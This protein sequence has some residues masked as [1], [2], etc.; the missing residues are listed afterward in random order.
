M[1][2]WSKKKNKFS[3]IWSV[4]PFGFGLHYSTYLYFPHSKQQSY[5]TKRQTVYHKCKHTFRCKRP[6]LAITICNNHG[7][8]A[9]LLTWLRYTSVSILRIYLCV[10]TWFSITGVVH[11]S[12]VACMANNEL[13]T[14]YMV[15]IMVYFK[16][17][18]RI[19]CLPVCYPKS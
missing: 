19:F 16:T 11:H 14:T 15:A 12:T 1:C 6:G 8:N 2:W 13:Q 5:R 4:G 18:F 10:Y 3:I 17:L 9:T 7:F